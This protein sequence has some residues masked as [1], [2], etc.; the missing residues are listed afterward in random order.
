M[1]GACLS[2][3]MWSSELKDRVVINMQLNGQSSVKDIRSLLYNSLGFCVDMTF[4]KIEINKRKEEPTHALFS[5]E[6]L[7]TPHPAGKD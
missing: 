3:K 2:R 6:N 1:G 7:T 4:V 5:D